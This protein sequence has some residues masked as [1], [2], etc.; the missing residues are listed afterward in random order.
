MAKKQQ[1]TGK[2]KPPPKPA[3]FAVGSKARVKAGTTIPAFED[4]PLGGWAGTITE[5][6]SRSNPPT[7]LIVWDRP[8]LGQMHPVYRKRCER[9]DLGVEDMWLA[10]D[11]LVPDDGSPAI[12]EQ[13]TAIRTRPLDPKDQDDRVRAVFGLTADDP[14]PEVARR[15]SAATTATWR[16]S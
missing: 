15:R 5:V 2:P 10:E 12:I 14:L 1:R 4:I 8:T 11:D 9:D 3:R 6:D 16:S 13:P 7:Y